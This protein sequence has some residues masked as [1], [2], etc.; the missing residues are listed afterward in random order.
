[1]TWL[2]PLSIAFALSLRS[3]NLPDEPTDY[4]IGFDSQWHPVAAHVEFE[5]ENGLPFINYHLT[6]GVERDVWF[7]EGSTKRSQARHLNNQK[8]TV[9]REW[10]SFFL[11]G[12]GSTTSKY[13]VDQVRG[14][15]EF[16]IPLPGGHLRYSS[17]F[18]DIS[19]VDAVIELK[20][21]DSEKRVRPKI[22][23][24]FYRYNDRLDWQVAVGLEIRLEESDG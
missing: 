6:G 8:V 22:T 4:L 15:M 17:N 18:G 24:R 3:P 2:I 11:L 20:E 7:V 12:V 16:G 13:D 9:G 14:V 23:G 1:M 5:R 21:R 10:L 19:I